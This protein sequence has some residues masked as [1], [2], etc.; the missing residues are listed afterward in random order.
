MNG[1]YTILIQGLFHLRFF[2]SMPNIKADVEVFGLG[3]MTEDDGSRYCLD[4]DFENH[5]SKSE[6]NQSNVSSH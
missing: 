3:I 2:P 1:L 5:T 4:D 6:A